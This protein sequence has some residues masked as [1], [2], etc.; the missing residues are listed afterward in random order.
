MEARQL[1]ELSKSIDKWAE[2]LLDTGKKNNLVS[3][4]DRKSSTLELLKPSAEEIF[5]ELSSDT[6][7]SFELFNPAQI[8]DGETHDY[9]AT[10]AYNTS[11][12]VINHKHMY[13]KSEFLEKFSH[14]IRSSQALAY[15]T[16]GDPIA[17]A[18]AIMKNSNE[19]M[20][21]TGINVAHIA[22]GFIHWKDTNYADTVRDAPLLL[23]PIQIVHK[24]FTDPCVISVLDNEVL[25]NKTFSCKLNNEYGIT[26]P[27]YTNGTTLETY[28]ERAQHVVSP[29]G[30]EIS[31]EC[32]V[33][34]FAFAKINMY[35][36]LKYN[37]DKILNNSIVA[38]LL[39][40]SSDFYDNPNQDI[41][42]YEAAH[43]PII[44]LCTV[45]D[46]DSS[47]I[48]AIEL[49]KS[50]Q[51]FVLQGPPGTGKSQTITN[52]IAECL[53]D[54]KKV[55]FVSEKL[56][57]LKVVYNKME[58]VGIA[59]FCLPLHSNKANKKDII[60]NICENFD[61]QKNKID[62]QKVDEEL[63][64]KIAAKEQ[65]D[66]YD[67]NLH[68]IRPVI[69]K[70]LYDL[71]ECHAKFDKNPDVICEVQD[72]STLG[73]DY[74]DTA[75]SLLTAYVDY[76]P[77]I[78]YDYHDNPWYGYINQNTSLIEETRI[79]DSMS[80]LANMLRE[81]QAHAAAI[82]KR[83]A[84]S[85]TC[86][87]DILFWKSFFSFAGESTLITPALLQK[88]NFASIYASLQ[89]LK[90]LSDQI[91]LSA[92]KLSYCNDRI[93]ELDGLA[94]YNDLQHLKSV[95]FRIFNSGYRKIV[96][97][98][99]SCMKTNKKPAYDELVL[100]MGALSTYQN[101]MNK[102]P[103]I[104]ACVI[105][106][107]GPAYKGVETNW[108]YVS[109]QMDTLKQMISD[110]NSFEQLEK[111][112]QFEQLEKHSSFLSERKIFTDYANRI[113][114]V[115]DE[116]SIQNLDYMCSNF[117]KEIVDI[118]SMSLDDAQT[119]LNGCLSTF[120]RLHQWCAFREL[121]HNSK[122]IG[123]LAFIDD[124]IKN[125]VNK[126]AIVGTFKKQ[127]YL[128]WI[129][130]IIRSNGAL[131][132]FSRLS[133]DRAVKKFAEK[134]VEQF[135]IN[136]LTL[137]GKLA[138]ACPEPNCAAPGSPLSVLLRENQKSRSKMDI[139]TLLKDTGVL[140]QQVKPCFMM[141]PLS[142]STYLDYDCMNFDIVIFDEASQMF[143]WDAI[144]AISRAKQA[145]IVGDSK[146]M[147][148]TNFF[149]AVIS[150]DDIDDDDDDIRSFGSILDL[151]SAVLPQVRLNWHYRSR[152]EE[153]IAFSNKNFYDGKLISFPS[154]QHDSQGLGIDYYYVNG[155][156]DRSSHNN[157]KEAEYVVDLIYKHIDTY[158]ARSLGVVAF[159]QSQQN[160]IDKLLYRRRQSTPEKEFF[161]DENKED[162]FFIKNLETVQGDERDTIIFSVGYGPDAK[163]VLSLNFGPLNR[164][165]GEKRL[166]VAV[167][168][169]KYNI[170]VA[171]SMHATDID[172]SRTKSEGVRLLR[173][174]LDFAEHGQIALERTERVGN[175][176]QF[177]SDFEFEVCEFLRNH[178][179]AVD[180]QVGCS[181]FRI[182]LGLKMRNSS[183][184]VLAIECDGAS[185]HSS[186]NAR[187]RDR[188]RQTVLEHMGWKFYRI[189]STEWFRNRII[190]QEKLLAAATK[191]VNMNYIHAA[192]TSDS[193]TVLSDKRTGAFE[194]A[195]ADVA[196]SPQDSYGKH[197]KH[198]NH[199]DSHCEYI[200][201]M[202]S[203]EYTYS[204]NLDG[205]SHPVETD[206][207]SFDTYKMV[208]CRRI[209]SEHG[210]T[211]FKEIIKD[212]LEVE[213]PLSEKLL[214]QRI[215]WYFHHEKVTSAVQKSFDANMRG[216]EK[217]GIIRRH[218]FLYLEDKPIVFRVPGDST[219]SFNQIAPEEIGEGML[220][221]I[222][223]NIQVTEDGLYKFIADLYGKK[224]MG[225][226]DA[227]ALHAALLMLLKSGKIVEHDNQI[228]L[229]NTQ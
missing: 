200:K 9:D 103:S 190:E 14:S 185:Y 210:Y 69:N 201:D 180:T 88:Q 137:R 120:D 97:D 53:H 87:K 196:N 45:V 81:L 151:A 138:S 77:T 208:D 221:V 41:D 18:R 31:R 80:T 83:Y 217:L 123:I 148:P 29:L 71:F 121:L 162:T 116:S 106:M 91:H 23:I 19:I 40:A 215:V 85:C 192:N 187:D 140:V 65:L 227:E 118:K 34:L 46:A 51:S 42:E 142:V 226:Y 27:E 160:L 8:L 59:D 165:G 195:S 68:S 158:P 62:Q 156:F 161:F 150:D 67:Y 94:Y 171:S 6:P 60:K 191:A 198:F 175:A 153:L 131:S 100:L 182:D 213:A 206:H 54:G 90:T 194:N 197:A 22:C 64:A 49:A 76:L 224:R 92:Q 61:I 108:D 112:G 39:G 11:L 154:A 216:C 78:G 168:R 15:S 56:A 115:L 163:G 36:D 225:K 135:K 222:S 183:D 214:L 136:Q 134:D 114:S 50:G 102:Y 193:I 107:L 21:E 145:V 167:T 130:L 5:Q 113:S 20:K 37:K 48:D 32:K 10:S 63:R 4:K 84:I 35:M 125:N 25:I 2:Q 122:N 96:S 126:D 174:Y 184:Y 139:R 128:Q 157:K 95:F 173:A 219:R 66:S 55:L 124:T 152:C 178:G 105:S 58:Q 99:R 211:G 166:N 43:D 98:V 33:G 176:D 199:T 146:Q 203:L 189:W 129:D 144:C 117:D 104:E 7:K 75:T 172:L 93:Y 119:K 159:S 188:L 17:T 73:P 220:R 132:Q 181:G 70:S 57:A 79:Q 16:S 111:L 164:D 101:A 209:F 109:E 205:I 147:P 82:S 204:K 89:Q 169:A 133:Q 12:D 186:K 170:Q 143:P 74:L 86:L 52:I 207:L 149:S 218:G 202:S 28:I 1:V 44:D 228:T 177:D 30:W 229:G 212:I 13:T 155:E 24:A 26:L 141:S 110:E 72:I 127:F 3:F 47:Q 223:K 38:R 179:F